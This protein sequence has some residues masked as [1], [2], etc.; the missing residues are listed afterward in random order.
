MVDVVIAGL[1]IK[2]VVYAMCI[3]GET[4][5][6]GGYLGPMLFAF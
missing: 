3:K 2:R 1:D 6:P 5:K 4:I